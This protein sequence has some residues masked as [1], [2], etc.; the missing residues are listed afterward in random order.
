MKEKLDLILSDFSK[1]VT[2]DIKVF[3]VSIF[4]LDRNEFPV[5][6]LVRILLID[7]M[8][9][10]WS[11]RFEKEEWTIDCKFKGIFS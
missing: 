2:E 5:P 9:F 7:I 1:D 4:Q 10:L 8:K 6:E 3:D 11:G